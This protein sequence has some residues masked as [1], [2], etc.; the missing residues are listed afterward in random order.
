[1]RSVKS[2]K[3]AKEYAA[4]I[5]SCM[6]DEQDLMEEIRKTAN[7]MI[8]EIREIAEKRN[9]KTNRALKAILLEQNQ[10]WKAICKIVNKEKLILR[11]NGFLELL[12]AEVPDTKLILNT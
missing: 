10:K 1:M 3:K 5:L 6:H 8:Q 9:I 12:Q 11:E 2:M 4:D 7:Q